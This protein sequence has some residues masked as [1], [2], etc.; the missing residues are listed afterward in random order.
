MLDVS[1]IQDVD[2]MGG[3]KNKTR[4][5][6]GF[7]CFYKYSTPTGVRRGSSVKSASVQKFRDFPEACGRY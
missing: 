4:R 3:A 7:G 6:E 1:S 2:L 5:A